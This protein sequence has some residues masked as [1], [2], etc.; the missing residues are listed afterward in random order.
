MIVG[1]LQLVL[2]N[3]PY[4]TPIDSDGQAAIGGGTLY[5]IGADVIVWCLSALP[6]G[7]VLLYGNL[8][9]GNCHETQT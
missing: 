1:S 2:H 9:R 6:S 4:V 8:M 3:P 5:C 7:R